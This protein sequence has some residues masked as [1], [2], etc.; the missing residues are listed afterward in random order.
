[1]HKLCKNSHVNLL[2]PIHPGPTHSYTAHYYNFQY[3]AHSVTSH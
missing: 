2:N 1:M 3:I